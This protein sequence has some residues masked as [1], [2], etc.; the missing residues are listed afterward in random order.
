MA[1]YTG[2]YKGMSMSK[3]LFHASVFSGSQICSNSNAFW[4]LCFSHVF[5]FDDERVSKRVH[6]EA[7][8]WLLRF[9]EKHILHVI[10][11]SV[12]KRT[13]KQTTIYIYIY[14]HI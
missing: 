8:V 3:A 4:S 2:M 14:L 7:P 1:R 11:M 6:A 5:I 13:K 12:R 10:H 9:V